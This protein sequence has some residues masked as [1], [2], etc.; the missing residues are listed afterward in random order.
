[1]VLGCA[2]GSWRRLDVCLHPSTFQKDVL[3]ISFAG[4]CLQ[5]RLLAG[6]LHF[7]SALTPTPPHQRVAEH[8]Q[9]IAVP[10]TSKEPSFC[11]AR[12][13][14]RFLPVPGGGEALQA[15]VAAWR[16][17]GYAAGQAAYHVALREDV[18]WANAPQDLHDLV[19]ASGWP[20]RAWAGNA[21]SD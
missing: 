6:P 17:R 13:G 4:L 15:M 3:C 14:E 12:C 11:V 8:G 1:M 19:R 9:H 16:E 7:I 10:R 2:C 21:G 20:E 5:P 18:A